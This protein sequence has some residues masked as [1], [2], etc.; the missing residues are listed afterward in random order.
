M[1]SIDEIHSDVTVG[2]T[3]SVSADGEEAL[4]E[5]KMDELRDIVR[6]LLAEEYERV[7]R[8]SLT[9]KGW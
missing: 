5:D 9:D 8:T 3:E 1:V 6:Q 7:L 2:S 4:D